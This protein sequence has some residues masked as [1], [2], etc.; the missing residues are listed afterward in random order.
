MVTTEMGA[1]PAVLLVHGLNGFKE[2]W[3]PLP[4]ALARAGR[5]VVAVDLPGFGDSPPLRGR[6]TG[7]EALAAELAPLVAEL[8]PVSLVG[9]SLGTQVAMLLAAQQPDR[10]P[11]MALIS[12][13]VVPR[14][15]RFPPKGLTDLLLLP[16]VGRRLARLA[17]RSIRRRP[18]RRRAA[19]L[20][21][22]ADASHI[23][24]HPELANL[25]GV[26]ADRLLTAD[27]RTMADWASSGVADDIRPLAPRLGAATLVV[28]G[29][30]DRLTPTADAE[31][32]SAALPHGRL[33]R[34]DGAAHFPHLE[35]PEA[36][37]PALVA[38]LS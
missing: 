5:R 30:E 22:V 31:W 33:V 7:P 35:R 20:A 25:L 29:S 10:I 18:E 9:H 26:A 23:D 36:V 34:V 16:V 8:A 14:S 21:Q 19:F 2:G 15:G 12:P 4:G 28:S 6:H 27:L 24:E 11:A 32:L 37:L 13:W 17:I 3:G 38:A 1:G